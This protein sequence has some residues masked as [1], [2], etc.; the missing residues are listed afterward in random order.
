M[1]VECRLANAR[2]FRWIIGLVLC[3]LFSIYC[4]YDGFMTDKYKDDPS[5]LWFNRIGAIVLAGGA[6]Y[7]LVGLLVIRNTLVRADDNGI[8]VNGKL[9][10]T[11]QSITGVDDSK[12]AKGLVSLFYD[13][14]DK[15]RKWIIDDHKIDRFHELIDEISDRRPDLLPPVEDDQDESQPEADGE[16]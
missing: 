9:T 16:A 2:R 15:E 12:Y 10:I 8:D 1:A 7:S 13:D 14:Q 3:V 5:N 11:W 4:F 6:V